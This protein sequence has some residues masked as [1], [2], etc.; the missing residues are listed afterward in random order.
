MR[1]RTFPNLQNQDWKV[2]NNKWQQGNAEK[3]ED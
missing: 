1:E 2:G 3:H